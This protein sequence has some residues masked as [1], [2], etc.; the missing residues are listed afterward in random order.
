MT[1]QYQDPPPWL[2][3]TKAEWEARRDRAAAYLA[4]DPTWK[5]GPDV[6]AFYDRMA[7][8]AK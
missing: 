7:K 1:T 2:T 3:W 6:V 8:G 4:T 5:V